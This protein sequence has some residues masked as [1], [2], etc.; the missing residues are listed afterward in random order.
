M[1]RDKEL[2]TFPAYLDPDMPEADIPSEF[3]V[4][5]PNKFPLS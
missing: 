5:W 3:A 1:V 2:G 4:T